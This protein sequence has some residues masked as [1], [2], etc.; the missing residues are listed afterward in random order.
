MS[1]SVLLLIGTDP[2]DSVVLARFFLYFPDF[3]NFPL[4][5]LD[6][7]YFPLACAKQ[8]S[9]HFVSKIIQIR[10]KMWLQPTSAIFAPTFPLKKRLSTKSEFYVKEYM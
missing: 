4:F 8:A 1:L 2:V 7:N 3:P 10:K 9:R 6:G 5:P